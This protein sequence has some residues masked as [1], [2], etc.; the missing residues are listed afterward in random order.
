MQSFF[1]SG[2]VLFIEQP[3][4]NIAEKSKVISS[5]QITLI[6]TEEKNVRFTYNIFEKTQKPTFCFFFT[7]DFPLV[8]VNWKHGSPGP[9]LVSDINLKWIA[10][11]IIIII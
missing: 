3:S 10:L 2:V 4:K 7:K 11:S 9:Y 6:V 8:Q 1:T 5:E